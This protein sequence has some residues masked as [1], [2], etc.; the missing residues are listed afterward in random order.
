MLEHAGGCPWPEK[1]LGQYA[2]TRW[3]STITPTI[4]L[5][6]ST[7]SS[8]SG[9]SKASPPPEGILTLSKVS[10]RPS[11]SSIMASRSSTAGVKLSITAKAVVLLSAIS[12][13]PPL[14]ASP[15]QADRGSFEDVDE[16]SQI[17]GKLVV[18]LQHLFHGRRESARMHRLLDD[19]TE[20]V[21]LEPL[22]QL[23]L[24]LGRRRDV[25]LCPKVEQLVP[26]DET[27]QLFG[28]HRFGQ[29]LIRQLDLGIH[30]L[31]ELLELGLTV[32]ELE[33][34]VGQ[35]ENCCCR[36]THA[37]FLPPAMIS[38]H[39]STTMRDRSR[40]SASA[41]MI[42]SSTVPRASRWKYCTFSAVCPARWIRAFACS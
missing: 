30:L 34:P 9:I 23:R 19:V 21:G 28:D 16:L 32:S 27:L 41:C 4:S 39:S 24:A 8:S 35:L 29:L 10:S 11:S 3:W 33:K 25:G 22:D 14:P 37:V 38:R 5:T 40:F 12:L 31:Q 26:P 13:V 42:R 7:S 6:V 1:A 18:L 36:L 15:A 2:L 20:A 17:G